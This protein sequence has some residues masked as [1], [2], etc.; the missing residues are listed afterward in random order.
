MKILEDPLYYR[1]VR[2]TDLNSLVDKVNFLIET[3]WAPIGGIAFDDLGYPRQAMTRD[4][5]VSND[6]LSMA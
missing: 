3:G 5:T 1:V 6:L 2:D 4:I